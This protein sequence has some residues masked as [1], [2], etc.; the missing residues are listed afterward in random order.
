MSQR[1]PLKHGSS[2]LQH[3]NSVQGVTK[4]KVD[5]RDLQ[6]SKGNLKKTNRNSHLIIRLM[7]SQPIKQI[8][9]KD[10][11]IPQ[12]LYK[13][14]WVNFCR[15]NIKKTVQST[16]ALIFTGINGHDDGGFLVL[17]RTLKHSKIVFSQTF[18]EASMSRIP[19]ALEN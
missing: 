12:G 13:L 15:Q 19:F 8:L 4:R 2:V 18:Q 1:W 10:Y 6:N 16:I 17:L 9:Q 7:V 14:V 11:R 5:G 3:P